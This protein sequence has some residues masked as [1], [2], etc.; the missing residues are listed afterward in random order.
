MNQPTT[1]MRK[2]ATA[3]KQLRIPISVRTEDKQR[4]GLALTIQGVVLRV[5]QRTLYIEAKPQPI[6]IPWKFIES[7]S[8]RHRAFEHSGRNPKNTVAACRYPDLPC[9]RLCVECG[10]L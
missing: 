2:A 9:D 8:I 10:G 1:V 6:P 3:M 7:I 4:P 5:T